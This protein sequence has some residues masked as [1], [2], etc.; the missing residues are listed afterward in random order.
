[1]LS[2]PLAACYVCIFIFLCRI[3]RHNHDGTE[4]ASTSCL[5]HPRLFLP[6][7]VFACLLCFVV[8]RTSKECLGIVLIQALPPFSTWIR[9]TANSA[10]V[11]IASMLDYRSFCCKS[12]SSVPLSPRRLD[13][14]CLLK[15]A[16]KAIRYLSPRSGTD[17]EFS[18]A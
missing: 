14:L 3:T 2:V 4:F 1:M 13:L 10:S 5:Q 18:T 9:C 8:H 12:Q 11:I 15:M 17:S 7:S 6:H 16:R